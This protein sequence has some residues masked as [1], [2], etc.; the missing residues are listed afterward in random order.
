MR[1]L[2]VMRCAGEEGV[3]GAGEGVHTRISSRHQL[4]GRL[5]AG[6]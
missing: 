2:G 3:R 5:P 1:R 4:Q 6:T